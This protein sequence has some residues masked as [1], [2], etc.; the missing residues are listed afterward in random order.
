MRT[1]G[2]DLSAA[3]ERTA[4]ATI[5]WSAD[6]AVVAEPTVGLGDD[7]LLDRLAD[8]GWVGIEAPFGWPRPMA[9]AIHEYAREGRW[10]SLAK[11][12]FRYRRADR[13]V[14]ETMHSETCRKLSPLR[15]SSDRIALTAWRLAHLREKAFDRSGIRFD[16]SGA[17]RVLEVYPPAALLLWGF[18]R[19]GYKGGQGEPGEASTLVREALVGAI[20]TQAPWLTWEPGAWEACIQSDDALDAVLAALIARAGAL[21]LTMQPGPGDAELARS[22]G[23]I[24]LPR[25]DCLATL[26]AG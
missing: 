15:V 10:S 16:R 18:E 19:N 6:R 9:A 21:G 1:V 4:A 3:D 7:E 17:D 11:A 26:L 5:E 23:W 12:D 2:V 8:A 20:E 22:E 13:F 14:R 25:K 24:H